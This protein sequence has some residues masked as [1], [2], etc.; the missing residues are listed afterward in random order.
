[1][2]EKFRK[3]LKTKKREDSPFKFKTLVAYVIFGA[4]ILVFAFFG[5]TPER[6]GSDLGGNAA[7]VN[8]QAISIAS[9]GRHVDMIERSANLN[10]D[11]FPAAQRELFTREF[12]RRALEELIMSEAIFQKA[13][14]LGLR[15]SD[16]E[17]RRAITAI[18][19][20]QENER[21]QR[22]KY[23][24]Y[25]NGTGQTP[26]A[27]ERQVR[28][29]LMTQKLQNLFVISNTLSDQAKDSLQSLNQ[30][31]LSFRYAKIQPQELVEN[32]KVSAAQVQDSLKNKEE[33]LKADYEVRKIDYSSP[34]R[35]KARHILIAVNE[36]QSR[37]QALKK[38]EEIKPELNVENFSHLAQK[39]SDDPGSKSK[40]GDL[41]FFERGRMIAAFE[42]AAF[43]LPESQV[44]EP[45]ES[46]FGFHIILVDKKEPG[47]QKSFEDVKEDVARKFLA[48]R[49]VNEELNN[50]RNLL[51]DGHT[52]GALDIFNRLG[53]KWEKVD[54]ITLAETSLPGVGRPEEA[55]RLLASRKGKTGL[56][57]EVKEW[58]GESYIFDLLSWKS[59]T[60]KEPET[61]TNEAEQLAGDSFQRWVMS[62]NET[63]DIERNTRLLQ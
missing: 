3:S 12:R 13:E 55:L 61:P 41:G 16:E 35:V 6:M 37:D 59:Q 54:K 9:F 48:R 11:Q 17:V 45:I 63:M 4:I 14:N 28:K 53:V 10:L 56:I 47:G 40:G 26:G 31:A 1:M 7:I 2:F 19:F 51:K 38:I 24:G 29:E 58:G 20:F 33:E 52:Q 42:Q 22:Q 39:Y 36:E 43:S 23:L 60:P 57:P 34:E 30:V 8:G 46:D 15:V 44:S 62:L 27:F 49:I 32:F 5:I 25:L 21:F 18:P 50:A